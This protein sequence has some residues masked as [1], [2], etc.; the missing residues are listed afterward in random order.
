MADI[1]DDEE[2][3]THESDSDGDIVMGR[4]RREI[5]M[6]CI[7]LVFNDIKNVDVSYINSIQL[8]N[9]LNNLI[10]NKIAENFIDTDI[11]IIKQIKKDSFIYRFDESK[12]I[13]NVETRSLDVSLPNYKGDRVPFFFSSE[14]G[15]I[16]YTNINDM[17]FNHTNYVK[18]QYNYPADLTLYNVEQLHTHSNTHKVDL[19]SNNKINRFRVNENIQVLN[20]SN[21]LETQAFFNFL[22]ERFSK[23][24]KFLE[25]VDDFSFILGVDTTR[26][27]W[28]FN[29]I[30]EYLNS[31]RLNIHFK[32]LG[33]DIIHI[34]SDYDSMRK[35][36]FR[37]ISYLPLDLHVFSNFLIYIKQNIKQYNNIIGI[38]VPWCQS[39]FINQ[40]NLITIYNLFPEELFLLYKPS[41]KKIKELT[42]YTNLT[43]KLKTIITL[44]SSRNSYCDKMFFDSDNINVLD[45]ITPFKVET[46]T[47]NDFNY[48][49]FCECYIGL[50]NLVM[51]HFI[52]I[53]DTSYEYLEKSFLRREEYSTPKSFSVLYNMLLSVGI[54][55]NLYT[56][57]FCKHN[58]YIDNIYHLVNNITLNLSMCKYVANFCYSYFNFSPEYFNI[59]ANF[60]NSFNS[61][62]INNRNIINPDVYIFTSLSDFIR[63]S[64]NFINETINIF[65]KDCRD[66]TNIK[67]KYTCV[68][69]GGILSNIYTTNEF[70]KT[71]K[72]IDLKII[73][74]RPTY[75]DN[76][77]ECESDS[78]CESYAIFLATHLLTQVFEFV[79]TGRMQYYSY[80]LYNLLPHSYERN[81]C[82]YF[83]YSKLRSYT[84][85]VHQN[86]SIMPY[87]KLEKIYNLHIN[88]D[89][90]IDKFEESFNQQNSQTFLQTIQNILTHLN[91]KKDLKQTTPENIKAKSKK[92]TDS[93]ISNPKSKI[94]KQAIE[95]KARIV[96]LNTIINNNNLLIT[97]T[98]Y[99]ILIY[100]K[101]HS[102]APVKLLADYFTK[103]Y[104][105]AYNRPYTGYGDSYFKVGDLISVN[106]IH[107][108]LHNEPNNYGI[109]D[110]VQDDEYSC[111][112]NFTSNS[113]IV[114]GSLIKYRN[115]YYAPFDYYIYETIKL[116]NICQ[117][118]YKYD[119]ELKLLNNNPLNKCS[120][121][122]ENRDKKR[123]KYITRYTQL[124]LYIQK[125]LI[126]IFPNIITELDKNPDYKYYSDIIKAILT[127]IQGI[128]NYE[129]LLSEP[130]KDLIQVF[131]NILID[132]IDE[133]HVF[134]MN[135]ADRAHNNIDK[136]NFNTTNISN[137]IRHYINIENVKNNTNYY[138]GSGLLK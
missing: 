83:Y 7:R 30:I 124:N 116:Y 12:N 16:C 136:Y 109:I 104:Y 122:Y 2:L 101:H 82:L 26:I 20:F 4:A 135:S 63:G 35:D 115:L 65:N 118:A 11:S 130:S 55:E 127:N 77:D 94:T 123:L 97:N 71:T 40:L 37:R 24:G 131:Y 50:Y 74:S 9:V 93:D 52:D 28:N 58:N 64:T 68:S 90:F 73:T 103:I 78:I 108:D 36:V 59:G 23:D 29:N 27:T 98:C 106:I 79:A 38:Y 8:V 117:S 134:K 87:L 21:H 14:N 95:Y 42:V 61:T 80:K 119:D 72:D 34:R 45:R 132:I 138:I 19:I 111:Y 3:P 18:T 32:T 60:I 86:L 75:F 13:V 91:L 66:P 43:N 47:Y 10:V 133:R 125:L 92:L 5:D 57:K 48:L 137:I 112:L 15:A 85:F 129:N 6:D 33:R 114:F 39:A 53:K 25:I 110:V 113:K 100:W 54:F 84:S 51:T 31:D 62:F 120:P 105:L 99:N 17:R 69:S 107:T 56:D 41:V 46:E 49:V 96:E 22:I 88:N 81:V 44:D 1:R 89:D 128:H 126:E 70:S 121:N 76:I 102:D 67:D